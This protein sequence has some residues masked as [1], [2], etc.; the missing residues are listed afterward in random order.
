MVSNGFIVLVHLSDLAA[1]Q[2][3]S[4]HEHEELQ[5]EAEATVL[6]EHSQSLLWERYLRASSDCKGILL[7]LH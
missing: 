6:F 5:G 2:W 3:K 7:L 4:G 1:K